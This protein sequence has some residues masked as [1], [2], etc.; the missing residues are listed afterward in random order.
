MQQIHFDNIEIGT[1][2]EP[3]N[4]K[5]IEHLDLVRY[6]GASGDFNP[7]HIDEQKARSYGLNGTIAHGM[8]MM[9]QLSRICIK[10]APQSSITNYNVKFKAMGIPGESLIC[11]GKIKRKL[12][13][14]GNK[15]IVIS[16]HAENPEGEIKLSGDFTVLAK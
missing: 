3:I 12:E 1:E 2:L 7:I 14:D 16:V 4:V 11:K 15:K 13:Q 5:M 6:A 8:Y 10:W 9:G